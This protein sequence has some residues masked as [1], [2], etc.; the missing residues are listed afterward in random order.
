MKMNYVSLNAKYFKTSDYA[1]I[2]QHDMRHSN[3][4]YKLEN[5]N[6]K[7]FEFEFAKFE[8]LHSKKAQIMLKKAQI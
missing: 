2:Y 4:T 5:T 1:H 3:V 7:N 6:Y 8:D